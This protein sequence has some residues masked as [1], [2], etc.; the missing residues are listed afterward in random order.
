[1]DKCADRVTSPWRR[2]GSFFDSLPLPVWMVLMGVLGGMVGIGG[3][4]FLYA[5][6]TSYLSNDPKACANCHIMRD[7]YDGWNHSS[8]KAVATCND[9]HT[10]HTSIVAKYAVKAINGWNHS[11]AF[12]TGRFHEPIRMTAMNR[13]VTQHACLYCHRAVT[14]LIRH[15]SSREPTD[16]IRCHVRVGHES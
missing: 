10:P 15:Q 2:C 7:V 4:T 5:Q 16:C 8:H 3:Y 13:A 12:T 11:V 9:C 6:G 1:M 14:S